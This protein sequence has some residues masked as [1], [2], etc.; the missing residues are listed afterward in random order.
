[1]ATKI[2]SLYNDKLASQYDKATLEGKWRAP[3]EV[4]KMMSEFGLVKSNLTVLDLG[5]GTGQ[6]VELF[7]NKNCKIYAVDISNEMLKVAKQKYKRIKTFKYDIGDGL[8]KL[9]FKHEF[10]DIVIAVGV[11]EFIKSI[12]TIIKDVHQLL[13]PD[14]YFAFTY[15]MLLPNH[16]FQRQRVQGNASG[17][18]KNPPDIINFKLCRRSKKEI[19]EILKNVGYQV[20]R[21]FKI[22]AF[23]KGH[24]KIP[25]YYGVVLVVKK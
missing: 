1:M 25:V 24:Q 19:N 14:S 12:E 7:V 8:D 15:E 22:K 4:N 2:I 23:L 6:S 20:V 3:N 16:N 10:F 13:K 11:L 17:Y 5:V 18:M 21:H 9:N